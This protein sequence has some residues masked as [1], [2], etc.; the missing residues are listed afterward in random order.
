LSDLPEELLGGLVMSDDHGVKAIVRRYRSDPGSATAVPGEPHSGAGEL[1][2]SDV[3]GDDDL[4][5]ENW[6][7]QHHPDLDGDQTLL[8]KTEYIT[9]LASAEELCSEDHPEN[10]ERLPGTHVDLSF[11]DGGTGSF[12]NA[13]LVACRGPVPDSQNPYRLPIRREVGDG[14]DESDPDHIR[15][16]KYANLLFG[17]DYGQGDVVE[18]VYLDRIGDGFFQRTERSRPA[19]TDDPRYRHFKRDLSKGTAVVC[20]DDTGLL[21][22]EFDADRRKHGMVNR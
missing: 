11:R 13:E 14:R 3:L 9:G 20:V 1:R 21:P 16:A 7:R 17:T 6:E 8:T 15:G 5:I 10:D 12:P 18:M 2:G 22:P 4:D 19:I